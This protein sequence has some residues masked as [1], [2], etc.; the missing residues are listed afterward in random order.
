VKQA[1]ARGYN[2]GNI[3][4]YH[5]QFY[6]WPL[7]YWVPGG[8]GVVCL[9]FAYS[10]SDPGLRMTLFGSGLVGFIAAWVLRRSRAHY[11]EIT[12]ERIT[13][14]GFKDWT[15]PK[16]EVTY[17]EPGKKGWM[18]EYDLFLKIYARG[19]EYSV[20]GGFLINEERLEEIATAIRSRKST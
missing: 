20:D 7:V 6:S 3:M 17:V 16:T 4:R 19:K 12:H 1:E 14:H 10:L 11:L 13:H 2:R 8:L 15:L 9:Y 18:E 5:K